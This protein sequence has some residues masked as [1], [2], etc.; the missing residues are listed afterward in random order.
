MYR[1]FD[2]LTWVLNSF[3]NFIQFLMLGISS[4][5][6]IFTV[7][8]LFALAK[9]PF[10]SS[11]YPL[12]KFLLEFVNAF[13]FV[14]SPSSEYIV[15]V[16]FLFV[17]YSC[18]LLVQKFIDFLIKKLKKY[19]LLCIKYEEEQL[20]KDLKEELKALNRDIH[21][22][23]VYLELTPKKI[24]GVTIVLEEQYQLLIK[25]LASKVNKEPEK[26]KNGYLFSDV[27]I[28][29]FDKYFECFFKALGSAAPVRYLFAVQIIEKH[30][31]KTAY[32]EL[33][34]LINTGLFDH[35]L[36][37]PATKLRY[38]H[39]KICGYDTTVVGNFVYHEEHRNIYE[40]R[41]RFF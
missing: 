5:T 11:M 3:G 24:P 25:Y 40:V 17:I 16:V 29:K 33:D 28:E 15:A 10:A 31:Y 35:V 36:V 30:D 27:D 26:Y 12:V 9:V 38:E 34:F 39:N 20:N 23:L 18:L 21:S 6:F 7:Y 4:Y 32:Q 14:L 37:T 19:R 2:I 13:N 22:A 41:D 1:I 8:V